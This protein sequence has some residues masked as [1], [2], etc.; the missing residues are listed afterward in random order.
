ML[1]RKALSAQRSN[2]VAD[3]KDYRKREEGTKHSGVGIV[4][5]ERSDW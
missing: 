5:L 4:S 3:G 2:V 1:K